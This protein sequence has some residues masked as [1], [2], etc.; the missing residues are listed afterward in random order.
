M[1]NFCTK[2]GSKKNSEGALIVDAVAV[3]RIIE[4]LIPFRGRA[5]L[6]VVV[7]ND[8]NARQLREVI[9]RPV[10]GGTYLSY[11]PWKR[12]LKTLRI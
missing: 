4:E 12:C 1:Q 3:P 2:G 5:G 8:V 11:V 9:H 6:E 10:V 7:V